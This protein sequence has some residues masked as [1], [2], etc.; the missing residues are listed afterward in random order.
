[1]DKITANYTESKILFVNEKSGKAE[2]FDYVEKC[3]EQD[4]IKALRKEADQRGSVTKAALSVLVAIL[5]A[6]RLQGYQGQNK[7]GEGLSKEFKEGLRDSEAAYLRP[8]LLESFHKGMSQAEKDKAADR[9]ISELRAGGVYAL[10][11]NYASKYFTIVGCLPCVYNTD[12]TPD[13]DRLLSVDIIKKLLS[14][15]ASENAPA[16]SDTLKNKHVRAIVKAATDFNTRTE[17]ANPEANEVGAAIAALKSMLA[18]FEGMARE[19]AEARTKAGT[20]IGATVH[21]GHDK[22]AN[23]VLAKAK[24]TPAMQV[25]ALV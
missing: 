22:T 5:S 14:I 8:I 4:A 2:G 10:V 3:T 15:H 17:E 16:E 6:E 1:M 13:T 18:S 7:P 25:A 21:A 20:S 24:A 9:Y 19:Y 11:K 12:G 23:A